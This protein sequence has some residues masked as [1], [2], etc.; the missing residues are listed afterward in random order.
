MTFYGNN[1]RCV[2]DDDDDNDGSVE[3][4][5]Y[6]DAGIDLYQSMLMIFSHDYDDYNET[7]RAIFDCDDF[8]DDNIDNFRLIKIVGS[9]GFQKA[10]SVDVSYR[11]R[12]M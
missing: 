11:E 8:S 1:E 2:G 12:E 7:M 6:D 4:H 10:V 5:K 9:I 3:I